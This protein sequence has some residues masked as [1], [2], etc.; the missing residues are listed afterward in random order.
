MGMQRGEDWGGPGRFWHQAKERGNR[1]RCGE[2]WWGTMPAWEGERTGRDGMD[3][4]GGGGR[5]GKAGRQNG[6]RRVRGSE[7]LLWLGGGS[8]ERGWSGQSGKV[9]WGRP[10]VSAEVRWWGRNGFWR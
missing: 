6:V 9:W 10:G 3:G 2:T 1:R 7:E 8:R 5:L 4:A